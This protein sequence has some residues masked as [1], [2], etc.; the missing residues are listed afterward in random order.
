MLRRTLHVQFKLNPQI[1][2]VNL[3]YY[4]MII[5]LEY[6]FNRS[7]KR[8]S[9]RWLMIKLH[10]LLH[11]VDPT[12]CKVLHLHDFTK[13]SHPQFIEIFQVVIFDFQKLTCSLEYL[14][15]VFTISIIL[16]K[17]TTYSSFVCIICL[18]YKLLNMET[19]MSRGRF[20]PEPRLPFRD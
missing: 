10:E 18:V 6:I 16:S 17:S 9:W 19:Y 15:H 3:A 8:E 2:R 20:P 11:T 13:F 7:F 1:S 4:N 12:L 5:S 14:L